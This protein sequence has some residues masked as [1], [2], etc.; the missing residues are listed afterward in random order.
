MTP[1]N[2][3]II[4]GVKH[5]RIAIKTL[6]FMAN[7]HF[8]KPFFNNSAGFTNNIRG[9][10]S[11]L[12]TKKITL[13]NNH[14][15]FASKAANLFHN[16]GYVKLGILHDPELINDLRKQFN[17]SI[18][19][20][21]YSVIRSEFKNK[22]Y[23]RALYRGFETIPKSLEL[24][25]DKVSNVVKQYYK[26]NFTISKFSFWRNYHVPENILQQTE[27]FSDRWHC[28]PC[29]TSWIK[30]FVYLTDVSEMDGPFNV[31]SKDETKKLTKMGFGT[32]HNTKISK[33]ILDNKD[34]FWKATGNSGS[35]LMCNC[36]LGIH[37]AGV[38]NYGRFR[39]II[40]IQF[41]PS[42]EPF[43]KDEWLK[44]FEDLEE[45]KIR[46]I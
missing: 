6:Y 42:N 37:R 1:P 28:D 22:I 27:A 21:K 17:N 13:E 5:P 8:G 7:I 39:D 16:Q 20:E 29:N 14:S 19:S 33:E 43:N 15:E 41:S 44:T 11:H 40:Q 31:K 30:L 23:S 12:T 4:E 2:S 3:R 24:V 10:I 32:R 18:E 26:T 9:K 46:K 25:N 34:S 35:S 36:N 38:P 45:P